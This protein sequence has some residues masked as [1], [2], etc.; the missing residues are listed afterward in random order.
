MKITKEMI[1]KAKKINSVLKTGMVLV[2]PTDK[3]YKAKD[4]Q[5]LEQQY[6]IEA[7]DS[8]ECIIECELSDYNGL[9]GVYLDSGFVT[10]RQL[11][12]EQWEVL[13]AIDIH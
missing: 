1:K 9:C 8:L 2:S 5:T 10:L 13:Q 12:V 6:N 4:V 7:S 3:I 11:I